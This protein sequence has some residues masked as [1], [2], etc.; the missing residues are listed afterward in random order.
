MNWR[1]TDALRPLVAN[2]DVRRA[3]KTL[4]YSTTYAGFTGVITG[5]RP[6]AFSVSVDSRFDNK[7]DI[8]LVKWILGDHTHHELTFTVRQALES[9]AISNYSDAFRFLNDSVLIGPS[10]I[11]L[12]GKARGEGAVISKESATIDVMDLGSALRNGS[13]YVLET[14]YDHWKEAPFFD[15]RRNPA[16]ACLDQLGPG[17]VKGFEGVFNVL[18]GKPN[19]NKLTTYTTLMSVKTGQYEAYRQY[20]EGL[21]SFW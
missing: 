11:I 4:Y 17:N 19:L 2:V 14:N 16:K 6:H 8:G 5:M 21:C 13:F 1:L 7:F 18:N 9:P 3:G 20:C 10:Y 15:D 12:G